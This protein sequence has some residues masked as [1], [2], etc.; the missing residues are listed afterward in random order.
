LGVLGYPQPPTPPSLGGVFLYPRETVPLAI[1][2]SVAMFWTNRVV[3][4]NFQ[5]LILLDQKPRSLP[6]V[7]VESS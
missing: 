3:I 1:A 2:R 6:P 7:F 5:I 4:K